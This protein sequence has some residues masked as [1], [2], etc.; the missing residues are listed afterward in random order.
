MTQSNEF[1]PKA[2]APALSDLLARYLRR[3]L[4]AQAAGFAGL[5][6]EA[7]VVPYEAAPV[8]PVDPRLAW[9]E[10]VAA[11]RFFNPHTDTG[12]WPVPP[13]WSGLVANQEPAMAAA[14][15]L[16]NFPQ[17]VRHLHPLLQTP[18]LAS[19]RPAATRPANAPGFLTWAA[20]TTQHQRYPQMLLVLGTL[21]LAREFEQAEKLLHAESAKV[22]N[23]WRAAWAN[24]EAALAWQRG[25]AEE[26][27]ALW[28]AQDP[29]APVLF[30]RGMAALFSDRPHEAASW[31]SRTVDLIPEDSS[32][33]HLARLY[34]ALAQMRS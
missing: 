26:A 29:V 2:A 34:L 31:L 14:F 24:E 10:A 5:E 15:C 7:E 22:P 25:R 27:I 18:K 16:G 13:D 17:S 23:E 1:S 6:A 8:Q 30:N 11:V 20:H 3:Q 4:D 9:N 19:L 32:W 21:R 33:H 12:A 28:Q